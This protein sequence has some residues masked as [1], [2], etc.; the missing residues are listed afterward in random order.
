MYIITEFWM[1]FGSVTL[2]YG[3]IYAT[4]HESEKLRMIFFFINKINNFKD[5]I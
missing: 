2:K 1:P 3:Y 4:T 5:V